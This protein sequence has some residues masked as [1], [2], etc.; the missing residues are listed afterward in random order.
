MIPEV[1][2]LATG[3]TTERAQIWAP[4]FG[5]AMERFGINTPKRSAA[6]LAQVAHESDTFAVILENLNYSAAALMETWPEHFNTANAGAYEHQPIKIA[7]LA[8]ANRMGNGPE[9]SGDGYL[10]RGRGPLQTTG[11]SDY[12]SLGSILGFDLVKSPDLLLQPGFGALAAAWEW[13]RSNLNLYADLGDFEKITRVING[14]LLG[15]PDRLARYQKALAAF[16]V[17]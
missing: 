1:L 15:E 4:A 9:E 2:E 3:A 8:Y 5:T 12:L 14:G 13:N 10:Y 17:A 6:F 7:N 16:G 11:K